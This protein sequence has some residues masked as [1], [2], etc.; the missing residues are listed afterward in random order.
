MQ[1]L[2]RHILV[3]A[4]L[5]LFPLLLGGCG[6]GG[7][8]GGTGTTVTGRVLD[9]AQNDAPLAGARV[10]I[11]GASTTTNPDGTF[12][13]RGAPGGA[14]TAVITPAG[15]APQT[16]A[17][18]PPVSPSGA[19]NIGDLIINLGQIRGRVLTPDGQPA[20][21]A[22]VTVIATGDNVTTEADG[23][24]QIDDLPA[25]QTE[26]TAVLGT[27][28]VTVQITIG[29][30]VTELG[31]LRLVNDPNPNPPGLPSTI[32]GTVRG[33]GG[34]LAGVRVELLQN[35]LTR[36][37]T[38]T[39]AAGNYGFYVPVGSYVVRVA[40]APDANVAVTN[41]AQPVRRDFSL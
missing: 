20:A 38:T 14:N 36:E 31:D 22:L 3:L 16:I 29:N 17:F 32:V 18:Q 23:R 13:L 40:G 25:T 28:S 12:T 34:A 21:G 11:G 1:R 30:G 33:G 2:R 7:G 19:T 5:L 10:Q 24:F 39:D 4:G 37:A 26:V 15:G 6:G 35:G 8:G 41:P 27:A 9:S